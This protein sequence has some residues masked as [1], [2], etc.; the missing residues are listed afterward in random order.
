MQ[1]VWAHY[2]NAKTAEE[3]IVAIV[4]ATVVVACVRIAEVTKLHH[5]D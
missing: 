3:Y 5:F 4:Q 1:L 2:E